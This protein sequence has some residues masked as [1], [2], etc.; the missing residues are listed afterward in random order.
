[1]GEASGRPIVQWSK[2]EYADANNTEDDLAIIA[3]TAPYVADEDANTFATARDLGVS[4]GQRQTGSGVISSGGDA[5]F[6]RFYAVT[7]GTVQLSVAP[8]PNF[9][10]LDAR[11]FLFDSSGRQL[12]FDDPPSGGVTEPAYG[13]N[14]A[15]TYQLPAPGYYYLAVDDAQRVTPTDFFYTYYGSIGQYT[16]TAQLTSTSGQSWWPVTPT[17]VLDTRPNALAA[18]ETR[19]LTVTGVAGVPADAT[20]VSLNASAAAPNLT[21]HLRIYPTGS[22]LPTASSL[23]FGTNKNVPNAVKVKVGTA[24]QISVY[25]GNR[26]NV[27]VD[28]V[29]YYSPNALDDQYT[30]VAP[31]RIVSMPLAPLATT[32]VKVTG[33]GGIP[34]TGPASGISSAVLNVGALNPNGTGHL[35]VW[36]AGTT[37]PNSSTNNFTTADG[38]M[39]LTIVKPNP[40]GQVSIYNGSTATVTLTVDTVGYFTWGGLGFVPMAPAR[41]VDTRVHGPLAAGS[42]VEGQVRG[43]AGVPNST[44]VVAVAVNVAAISPSGAGSIDVGPSGVNPALPSFTHPPSQDVANLVIVP[45]G[46]D[47]KIRLRN[48]SLGTTG[49][50]ADIV[51]YYTN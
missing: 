13:M 48:N 23:N 16:V 41:T 33:V 28:I 5:D 24:G 44:D 17:R 25:A 3:S 27:L 9:P 31:K 46:A 38:R 26:T 51:G 12:A 20:A 36:E 32:T 30:P 34:T 50:L 42:Y 10:N 1:M 6:F 35:R 22:P 7:A 39:N 29:G 45:V 14:A 40:S 15:I 49:I 18:G 2:G 21:G 37:M 47:G 4:F 11:L 19:N 43:F 8:T